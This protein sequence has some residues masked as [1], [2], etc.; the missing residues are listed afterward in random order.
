MNFCDVYGKTAN[1][2]VLNIMPVTSAMT[3]ML[4]FSGKISYDAERQNIL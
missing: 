3:T 4:F 2:P 1:F